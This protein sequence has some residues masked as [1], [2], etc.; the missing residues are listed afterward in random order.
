MQDVSLTNFMHG[1]GEA[2]TG[3]DLARILI[4][5]NAR[6]KD[7]EDK[8]VRLEWTGKKASCI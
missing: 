6:F 2:M 4:S 7:L 5:I 8:Q 1:L 3:S